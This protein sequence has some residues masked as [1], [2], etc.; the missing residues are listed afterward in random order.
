M[1]NLIKLSL[2]V[3]MFAVACNGQQSGK[4][5]SAEKCDTNKETTKSCDDWKLAVQSWSFHNFT[6]CE[7]ISK[8]KETGVKYIE[9]YPGQKIGGGME[10]TTHFTMNDE[11]KAFIKDTLEKAGLTW[12]AYGV[13]GAKDEAEWEK[14]FA[15]ADEMN[16]LVVNTEPPMDMMPVVDKMA[17]KYNVKVGLHNH[18]K[19]TRYWTPD[20]VL[21]AAE[22]CGELVGACADNGHWTRSGLEPVA[23]IEQLK[24][25]I[26]SMHL[27]DMHEKGNMDAHTVPYGT[28]ANDMKAILTKLKE[29]GFKGVLTIEYEHNW[30]DNVDE[31][32]QCVEYFNKTVKEL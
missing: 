7:A 1:K 32:K 26:M 8:A 30:D 17:K 31:I 10:G 2:F 14:L 27:K 20:S 29:T 19:P 15:F 16:I 11:A 22:G 24:G 13:T 6:L 21:Q 23:C 3:A 5:A 18:A 9:I 4:E 12:V 28:G 25:R